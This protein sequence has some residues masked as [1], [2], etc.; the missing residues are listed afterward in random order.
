M[1]K[2]RWMQ[3]SVAIVRFAVAHMRT[4]SDLMSGTRLLLRTRRGEA[5]LLKAA[6]PTR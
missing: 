5:S 2:A 6:D 4:G 1:K 3:S